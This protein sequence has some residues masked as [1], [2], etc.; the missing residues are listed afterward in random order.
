[1]LIFWEFWSGFFVVFPSKS[2]YT[3]VSGSNK[4]PIKAQRTGSG[5]CKTSLR[6]GR[7]WPI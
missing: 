5:L 3:I 7:Q 2:N 1:M 6:I 4:E